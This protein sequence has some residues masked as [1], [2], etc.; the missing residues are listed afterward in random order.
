IHHIQYIHYS[1]KNSAAL[2]GRRC[3]GNA[4]PPRCGGLAY[5]A[6]SGR[7]K[8]FLARERLQIKSFIKNV[9]QN[10]RLTKQLVAKQK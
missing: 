3:W 7:R 9:S 2:T 4:N 8:F 1:L 5:A 6:L 10:L